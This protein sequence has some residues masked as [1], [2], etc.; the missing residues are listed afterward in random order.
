MLFSFLKIFQRVGI[1]N[2]H[3]WK[4]KEVECLESILELLVDP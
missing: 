3:F 2:S 4:L 1:I